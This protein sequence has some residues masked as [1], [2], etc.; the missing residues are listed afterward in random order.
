MNGILSPLMRLW[1]FT[2]VK[3]YI[4]GDVLDY[5]C[6]VG[7]L[8]KYIKG[9]TSYIGVD[10][11]DENIREAKS[12]NKNLIF[13][14]PEQLSRTSKFDTIVSLAVIEYIDDLNEFFSTFKL[15]LRKNGVIIITSP[16][17]MSKIVRSFLIKINLLGGEDDENRLW[18][19]HKNELAEIA[20]KSGFKLTRFKL[21]MLGLNQVWIFK[22]D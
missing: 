20:E 15:T 4:E 21:F 7:Y 5:G 17:P 10:V 22:L 2:V 14:R 11:N 16:H 18:L 13:M 3:N 6:G 9:F 8:P 12:N 19:P 1:R